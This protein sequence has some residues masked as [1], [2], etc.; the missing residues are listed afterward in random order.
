MRAR[1][2]VPAAAGFIAGLADIRI[3]YVKANEQF[4]A[5]TLPRAVGETVAGL[6]NAEK[7]SPDSLGALVSL[8]YNRGP[9]FQLNGKR[10]SEMRAIRLHMVRNEPE[11]IPA[12]IRGMKHLWEGVPNMNGLLTRRELEARLF[13]AGM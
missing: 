11:K 2:E 7:L 10:Y 4:V 12:E 6:P 1:C 5:S 8:V 9:S 13:E 3:P